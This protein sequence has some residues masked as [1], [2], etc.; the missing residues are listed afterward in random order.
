[1]GVIVTAV[2]GYD[3]GYVW[4]NQRQAVQEKTVGGY[5]IDAAQDGEPPGR[6]WGP[7]A[8]AMSFAEGQIVEREPYDQV[9]QQLDPRTGE[10]LGRSRGNYTNFEAHLAGLKAAEPYATAERL[11]ELEREAAQATRQA[12]AYTDMTV[13]F[14]KSIS[15]LHASIREN[16]RRAGLVGDEVEAARWLV[17][18]L[19]FQETLQAAN[20]AGLEYV[21]KWA[22]MTRTGYHGARVDGQE[23]GRYEKGLLMVSSWLQGTSRDGDPQDHIHNQLA[24]LVKT[25][26]DGKHRALD[27]ICLRQVLGAVQAIV[28]THVECA[29][30]QRF[31]VEWVPRPDGYGNEIAGITQQQMDA[32]SSRTV[33]IKDEL[34]AA[35]AEWTQ[36]YGRAPNRRQLA[37]IQQE[38]TL[39]SR[40]GKREGQIDWDALCAKWDAKLGGDLAAVAPSMSNLREGRGHHARAENPAPDQAPTRAELTRAVQRALVLVQEKQSTWTR[41]DLLKQLGLAMPTET[42]RMAPEAA[43]ALLQDLADEAVSGSFEQVVCLEAPEWPPVPQHLRRELDGRSAYTRPGTT[44]YATRVQ[45]S[46]EEKLLTDAQKQGAP[47]LARE[48]AAQALGTD[49]DLLEAQLLSRAQHTHAHDAES[50]GLRLDQSA[51]LYHALT[52]G[53]AVELIV[54]PAGSGKTRVLAEA[55]RAWIEADMGEVLGIATAQAARNV[56]TSAGVHAAEN[57]AVFLGHLPGRRGARGI[58]D[59]GP[60]TLL[61]IDEASMMSLPDLAAIVSYAATKGAKVIIAGDQ[62]QLAS[63]PMTCS[64]TRST[65]QANGSACTT[66]SRPSCERA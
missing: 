8:A 39:A 13:S 61:V 1:M 17:A 44:H 45:L 11:L 21:Q 28:A 16:A 41:S 18:E 59:I 19:D 43:V 57:S 37:H 27:T 29:L 52:S 31:G 4:K 9:Y 58:R 7:G 20:R 33:T 32:Y 36:K 42:R 60:G 24:R 22:G 47:H 63:S 51:V 23:P 40:N 66:C 6:W 30:T 53:R 54:G 50:A 46:M 35:V 26:S 5:Y 56:L 55:S 38:V 15:I 10:R 12:A 14:S 48:Q 34:P 2:S 49:A 25:V 62:Q 3:L 64:F 65:L